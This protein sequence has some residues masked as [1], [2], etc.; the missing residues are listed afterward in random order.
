M[1][2]LGPHSTHGGRLVGGSEIAQYNWRNNI[3]TE[4]VKSLPGSIDEGA[5]VPEPTISTHL[6]PRVWA[7]GWEKHLKKF[8]LVF[9]NAHDIRNNPKNPTQVVMTVAQINDVLMT[10]HREFM[11]ELDK[12]P[13]LKQLTEE[14]MTARIYDANPSKTPFTQ[15]IADRPLALRVS[16]D[17]AD[18][19]RFNTEAGLVDTFRFVG[20]IDS[21]NTPVDRKDNKQLAIATGGRTFVFNYWG[22]GAD[23]QTGARLYFSFRR[24]AV[25]NS[26]TGPYQLVPWSSGGGYGI[27]LTQDR[28]YRDVNGYMRCVKEPIYIG[29]V[30]EPPLGQVRETV[31]RSMTIPH[32]E[33]AHMAAGTNNSLIKLNVANW[34]PVMS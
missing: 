18:L 22:S 4:I 33:Q 12:T 5:L 16:P 15:S 26:N 7:N 31:V 20:V 2:G 6:I 29:V 27:P 32:A 24:V 14:Q 23:I 21:D 11:A 30:V 34:T 17:V 1:A 19:I 9:V 3:S 13:E 28:V 10:K 25:K 8:S